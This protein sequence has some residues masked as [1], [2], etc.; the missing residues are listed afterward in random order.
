MSEEHAMN[1]EA[2]RQLRGQ[3]ERLKRLLE[4]YDRWAI[5]DSPVHWDDA[6][7]LRNI[8][9]TALS[10]DPPAGWGKARLAQYARGR[11]DGEQVLA[12][13]AIQYT[14]FM[15]DI[16]DHPEKW[17]REAIAARWGTTVEEM[18]GGE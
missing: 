16:L 5:N 7:A 14:E 9:G 8:S 10:D 17:T 11:A 2:L 13:N 12:G 1:P 15:L 4:S 18:F 6:K 3:I